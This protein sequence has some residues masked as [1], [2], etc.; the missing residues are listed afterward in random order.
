MVGGEDGSNELGNVNAIIGR[1]TNA[2]NV[3]ETAKMKAVMVVTLIGTQA[4]E[5]GNVMRVILLRNPRMSIDEWCFLSFQ[6]S[7]VDA[8]GD[9][10]RRCA[11]E[12]LQAGII[13]DSQLVT[14]PFMLCTNQPNFGADEGSCIDVGRK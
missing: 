1:T 11:T 13:A 6:Q 7:L 4:S 2:A 14:L 5:G 9:S 10:T 8:E 3:M 12:S